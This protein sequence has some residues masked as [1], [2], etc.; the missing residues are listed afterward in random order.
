M[1]NE[2]NHAHQINQKNHSSD[3]GELKPGIICYW[4]MEN[5][6]NLSICFRHTPE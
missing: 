5:L 3:K 4:K 2:K 1:K 6:H